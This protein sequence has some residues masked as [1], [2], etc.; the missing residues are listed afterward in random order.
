MSNELPITDKAVEIFREADLLAQR[1]IN[2][3]HAMPLAEQAVL[4]VSM[5][6]LNEAL[7]LP[8]DEISPLFVEVD[9]DLIKLA[10]IKEIRIRLLEKVKLVTIH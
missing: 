10:E 5:K 7:G 9:T 8:I 3:G 4:A 1:L 6:L 2:D